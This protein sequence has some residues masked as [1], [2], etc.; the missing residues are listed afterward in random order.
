MR[1]VVVTGLGIISPIG[2]NRAEV[3]D[4]LRN[5]TS[6]IELNPD[7]ADRNFR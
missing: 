4:A 1:R 6:G 5:G 2:N 7:Q 3:E